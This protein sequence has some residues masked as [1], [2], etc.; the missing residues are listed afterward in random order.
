MITFSVILKVLLSLV[1]VTLVARTVY[2][3][4]RDLKFVLTVWS[5]FR[6][7]MFCE[8]VVLAALT[9]STMLLLCRAAPVLGY[10]WMN[11]L[12]GPGNMLFAPTGFADSSNG[13]TKVVPVLFLVLLF[14]A[15][16]FLARIEERIFR[17]GYL[18]TR[19]IVKRSVMFGLV[20]CV[21]GVPIGVGIALILS[22]FF[23][24]HKYRESYLKEISRHKN[25]GRARKEALLVST[26]YHACY[27]TVIVAVGCVGILVVGR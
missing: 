24:A 11:L 16:P 17:A 18:K 6:L 20:H 9:I 12:G 1:S 14:V 22:G 27:N 2:A 26:T 23:Y 19:Q 13:W 25:R 3:E 4:R 7:R 5:R 8:V 15:I 10:G 21:A